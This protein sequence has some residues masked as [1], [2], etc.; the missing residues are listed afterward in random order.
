MQAVQV[1]GALLLKRNW[2]HGSCRLLGR[3]NKLL[4]AEVIG[5]GICFLRNSF[6]F[7][8]AMLGAAHS[9]ALLMSWTLQGADTRA[10]GVHHNDVT[11]ICHFRRVLQMA[12]QADAMGPFPEGFPPSSLTSQQLSSIPPSLPC[13]PSGCGAH[14]CQFGQRPRA[15]RGLQSNQVQRRK[16]PEGCEHCRHSLWLGELLRC[17]VPEAGRVLWGK[18][19][20]TPVAAFLTFSLDICSWP[21]LQTV[22]PA[23]CPPVW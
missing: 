19:H 2:P 6:P 11:S 14:S 21:L 8:R 23:G 13:A 10:L 3:E 5:F 16:L 1:P 17:G 9:N 18:P 22:Y 15:Q 12:G 4:G 7:D 20:S